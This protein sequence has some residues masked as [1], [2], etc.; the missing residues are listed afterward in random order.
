M[1]GPGYDFVS[2]VL[3]AVFDSAVSSG[4]K[5]ISIDATVF[6]YE[7]GW[8][9]LVDAMSLSTQLTFPENE[10]K[11]GWGGRCDITVPLSYRV[12]SSCQKVANSI[13]MWI[14]QY[15]VAENAQKLRRRDYVFFSDLF[16]IAKEG[17]L[18]I[19]T[20]TTPRLWPDLVDIASELEEISFE[21]AFVRV[22]GRGNPAP[23][24]VMRKTTSPHK[25]G[26]DS[27][28]YKMLHQF[29]S[30]NEMHERKIKNGF[31]RQTKKRRGE[32]S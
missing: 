22:S 24:M 31:V 5:G 18:F 17:S 15:C 12:N 25:T 13:D 6:D 1:L 8:S 30:I 3:V 27:T 2:T 29:R 28:D 10:H 16:K 11:C 7:E 14:C 4:W 32:K 9:D 26:L 23:Q 19:F 21:I 20:E